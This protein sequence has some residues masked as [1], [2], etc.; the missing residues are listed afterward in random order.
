MVF[1][2]DQLL[3]HFYFYSF[4]DDTCITY[5]NKNLKT[6]ESNINYDLKSVTEWLRANRLSLNV[7]KTKLLLFGSKNKQHIEGNI[8]IK[9]QGNRLILN[10]K[11]LGLYIDKNLSWNY[12]W[13]ITIH[14]EVTKFLG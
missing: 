3:V 7:D 6:L 10:V 5:A 9:L 2:K 8:S 13:S 11:Y 4:A 1:L 14:G 12:P